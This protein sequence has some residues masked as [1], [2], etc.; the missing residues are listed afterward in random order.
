MAGSQAVRYCDVGQ[1]EVHELRQMP[2]NMTPT[3][4]RCPECWTRLWQP[5]WPVW[6]TLVDWDDWLRETKD[7]RQL[8]LFEAA[9]K[10]RLLEAA[11]AF[12]TAKE[13]T[14]G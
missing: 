10:H 11:R 13:H 4:W 14:N 12:P 3:G 8:G 1:H 2:M 5:H 7:S 6:S 9:D